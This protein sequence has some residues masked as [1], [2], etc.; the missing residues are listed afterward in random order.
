MNDTYQ[1]I[2]KIKANPFYQQMLA[3][4]LGGVMYDVANRN[5]YDEGKEELIA[6][7]KP[8]EGNGS[9]DG[10]MKGAMNFIQGK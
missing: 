6:L 8:I 2:E 7:Y 5:K 3:D 9:I 1:V 10:I 4:S